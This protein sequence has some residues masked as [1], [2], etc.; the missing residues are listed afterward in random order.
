M[1]RTDPLA[2]TP[3]P[4]RDRSPL[5]ANT[6]F[7]AQDEPACTGLVLNL[8]HYRLGDSPTARP[9]PSIHALDLGIVLEQGDTATHPT[10]RPSSRVTKKREI[11]L[12]QLLDRKAVPLMLFVDR[13][14]HVI[15]FLD[16]VTHFGGCLDHSF[17][18]DA[19]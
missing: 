19:H 11:R 2:E 15:E 18:C 4:Y 7:Q 16:Q 1:D 12:E 6:R 5:A 8:A 14:E 13:T 3:C 10:A 9:W 17:N